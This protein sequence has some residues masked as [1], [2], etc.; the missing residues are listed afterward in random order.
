[1]Y[2]LELSFNLPSMM[3][4]FFYKVISDWNVLRCCFWYIFQ[5]RIDRWMWSTSCRMPQ[6]CCLLL[7]RPSL[8]LTSTNVFHVGRWRG[9]GRSAFL[10][11]LKIHVF[12][13]ES[14]HQDIHKASW[15][16][17]MWT[18]MSRLNF[19]RQSASLCY[20]L[21]MGVFLPCIKS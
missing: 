2:V 16:W 18:F 17:V 4:T 14:L 12:W 3:I 11:Q 6:S 5:Y 8:A 19:I 21:R 10:L 15:S 1:M 7:A 9:H 13:T 20:L